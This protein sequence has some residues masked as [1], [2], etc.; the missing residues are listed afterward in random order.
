MSDAFDLPA[1]FRRIGFAGRAKPDLATLSA[2]NALHVSAIPFE[3]LDPLLGRTP[4]LDLPA[5][6]AKLVGRRRGGYCFEQNA[7]FGAAL[8]AI[9]FAVTPLSARVRWVS[10]MDAPM[11]PA[12]HMLLKVDLAEGPHIV[13]VG[14]GIHLQDA[15]LRLEI[16]AEQITPA[17]VYRLREIDGLTALEM[18][19]A[20]AWRTGFLFNLTPAY[21]ADYAMANW[22]TSTSPL[23]RFPKMLSAER[24][25]NGV[26]FNLVNRRLTERARGAADIVWA[27][28][29]AEELGEILDRTFNLA[30]PAP[31]ADLWARI[32]EE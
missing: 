5:L 23:S 31:L 11:T 24:V 3:N 16:G 17:G 18:H 27:I 1:Y 19:Q 7:V 32:P 2:I 25:A 6:E 4:A 9:G 13:D 28:S 12:T 30:C 21:P 10:G 8:R 20:G 15:P 22:Y 14:F 26:R 29:S